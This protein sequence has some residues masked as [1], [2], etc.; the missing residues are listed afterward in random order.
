MTKI[1][2]KILAGIL[3]GAMILGGGIAVNSAYADPPAQQQEFDGKHKRPER[4]QMTEEQIN[5]YSK[6]LAEYYGVNQAEIATALKNHVHFED[7][8][9]AAQLAKISG[10]SFSEVLAMKVDWHQ[11]AEKLGVTREQMHEAMKN[12]HLEGLAQHS[13]LDKKTVESL[14]N[15]NYDPH[16]ITIAGIIASE[17]G[18][19]VKSVLAKRKL[20]NSWDDVAKE[21]GVDLKKVMKPDHERGDKDR[22]K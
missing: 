3:S 4:P 21:F 10:K 14:L 20:N 15:E 6:E 22:R 7:I 13:K 19:N 1:K 5:Q 16:D 17:S 2:Q 12:E 8:R 11:V 18:K 9:M